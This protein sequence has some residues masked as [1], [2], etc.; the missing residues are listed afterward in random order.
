MD[1]PFVG[2]KGLFD[3][4]CFFGDV[5]TWM[6]DA[7]CAQPHICTLNLLQVRCRGEIKQHLQNLQQFQSKFEVEKQS[8]WNEVKTKT[9]FIDFD[10]RRLRLGKSK[11]MVQWFLKANYNK[12]RIC[13]LNLSFH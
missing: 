10:H 4:G 7:S 5:V 2:G 6:E 12:T 9:F 11:V 13:F 1:L 3:N 8:S